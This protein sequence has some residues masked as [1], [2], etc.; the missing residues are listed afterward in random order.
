M[1]KQGNWGCLDTLSHIYI[2]WF[3][4]C[5]LLHSFSARNSFV[6]LSLEIARNTF[7]FFCL[8]HL[9]PHVRFARRIEIVSLGFFFSRRGRSTWSVVLLFVATCNSL[10]ERW[11]LYQ[12][13]MLYFRGSWKSFSYC[14]VWDKPTSCK[15]I[16]RRKTKRSDGKCD[17]NMQCVLVEALKNCPDSPPCRVAEILDVC[18]C[19]ILKVR[20]LFPFRFFFYTLFNVFVGVDWG[21]P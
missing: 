11:R 7:S 4:Y 12:H 18:A 13:G 1:R 3:S 15:D 6:S 5:L 10:H 2:S 20:V 21:L 8:F 9:D 14:K 17:C 19:W 16:R